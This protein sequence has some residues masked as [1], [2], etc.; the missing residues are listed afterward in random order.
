MRFGA[1]KLRF[2]LWFFDVHCM[3]VCVYYAS[4]LSVI[5]IRQQRLCLWLPAAVCGLKTIKRWTLGRG[6]GLIVLKGVSIAA[7]TSIPSIQEQLRAIPAWFVRTDALTSPQRAVVLP[8]QLLHW[9]SFVRLRSRLRATAEA[10]PVERV[11][12]CRRATDACLLTAVLATLERWRAWM[13]SGGTPAFKENSSRNVTETI[14][15][16]LW[17]ISTFALFR[18]LPSEATITNCFSQY[19]GT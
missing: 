10:L 13:C 9:L 3:S 1:R 8:S 5:V 2:M 16:E 14:R 4:W 17:S 15:T 11:D 18:E 19:G 7:T 12:L 6:E